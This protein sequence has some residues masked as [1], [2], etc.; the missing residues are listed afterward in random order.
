MRT[1]ILPR[2]HPTILA[3][4]AAPAAFAPNPASAQVTRYYVGSGA[5]WNTPSSWSDSPAGPPG[6]TVPASGDAASP[7]ASSNLTVPFDAAYTSPGLAALY[8]D[9][10]PGATLTLSQTAPAS[11]LSAATEYIGNAGSAA[12][13]QSDGTNTTA[14]DLTLAVASGSTGAYT[15]SNSA[16][17]NVGQDEIVGDS[18]AATF[19]QS[20]GTH[21]ITSFLYVS[22]LPSASGTF[23]LSAGLV[24]VGDYTN[25]PSDTNGFVAVGSQ[26][27]GTFVHSGGTLTMARAL[28][29]GGGHGSSGVYTLSA[30]ALSLADASTLDLSDNTLSL[31]ATPVDTV[32]SYLA[33]HSLFSSTA[34]ADPRR[35]LGYA[36]TSP[37]LAR[38]PIRPRLRGRAPHEPPRALLGPRRPRHSRPPVTRRRCRRDS[39]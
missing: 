1:P 32:R 3:A 18:G 4:A 33:N 34:D 38:V 35:A 15:L 6:A 13:V 19:T 29:L 20:G 36:G 24:R 9:A 37:L 7:S 25:S 23:N 14:G 28:R 27:T 26:G 2:R 22:H 5:N 17:L 31:A 16:D 21:S 12:F 11:A 39:P 10:T 8:L 30:S